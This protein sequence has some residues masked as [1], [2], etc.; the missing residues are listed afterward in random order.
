M[1]AYELFSRPFNLGKEANILLV[2]AP[3]I[4]FEYNFFNLE[5]WNFGEKKITKILKKVR[6]AI[7]IGCMGCID[8]V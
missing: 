5:F 2:V 4:A 7:L 6:M 3:E 1:K 8:F